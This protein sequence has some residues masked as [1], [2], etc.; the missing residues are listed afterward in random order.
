[1][2]VE[3]EDVVPLIEEALELNDLQNVEIQSYEDDFEAHQV[4][5]IQKRLN[6]I[7]YGAEITISYMECRQ[8]DSMKDIFKHKANEQARSLREFEFEEFGKQVWLD[9]RD[10][11]ILTEDK[12]I[13]AR[14]EQ[15]KYTC[16][17][18]ID[19]RGTLT[20]LYQQMLQLY[21]AGEINST[22]PC[23]AYRNRKF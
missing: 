13:T 18:G 23:S 6:G 15:C 5:H 16:K 9:D 7:K 12:R 21:A 22:C 20:E 10:I 17:I 3:E 8:N 2:Q 14:C 1:M 19:T 4:F 11:T